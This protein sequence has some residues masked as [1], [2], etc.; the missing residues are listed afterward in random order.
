MMFDFFPN[1]WYFPNISSLLV[2]SN[3]SR[4]IRDQCALSNDDIRRARSL[5]SLIIHPF[6][7]SEKVGARSYPGGKHCAKLVSSTIQQYGKDISV[8]PRE[9]KS[10]HSP[11]RVSLRYSTRAKSVDLIRE[12]V[13]PRF[14]RYRHKILEK[15]LIANYKI[16]TRSLVVAFANTQLYVAACSTMNYNAYM[17]ADGLN[18]F[19]WLAESAN[20]LTILGTAAYFFC[21]SSVSEMLT[22]RRL[23]R[24]LSWIFIS[25]LKTIFI[26]VKKRK[27]DRA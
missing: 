10:I 24:A 4:L 20:Y 9:V 13:I 16:F 17:Y 1:V 12:A 26:I 27:T 25:L 11:S 5:T 8:G 18:L 19:D 14:T 7:R 6:Y 22:I 2:D 23:R 15:V 3:A 21:S